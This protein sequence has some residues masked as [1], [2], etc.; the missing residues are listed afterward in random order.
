MHL[1]S[2]DTFNELC[3]S[4]I[5]AFDRYLVDTVP[6]F[7][8]DPITLQKVLNGDRSTYEASRIAGASTSFDQ[9]LLSSSKGHEL[10]VLAD[11]AK[12]V[13]A[14]FVVSMCAPSTPMLIYGLKAESAKTLC[15]HTRDAAFA[16][17]AI[18]NIRIPEE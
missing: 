1:A 8:P 4:S 13:M 17:N 3:D 11:P 6:P 5:A 7:F 2:H 15:A 18:N 14:V 16:L 9:Y 10:L 12:E